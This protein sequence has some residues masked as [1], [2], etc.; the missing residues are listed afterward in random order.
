MSNYLRKFK[1][2]EQKQ[3]SYEQYRKS[4]LAAQKNTAIEK[5]RKEFTDTYQKFVPSIIPKWQTKLALLI[6]PM[7]YN[8]TI[9]FILRI[10]SSKENREILL[11]LETRWKKSFFRMFRFWFANLLYTIFIRSMLK[12]RSVINEFGIKVKIDTLHDNN[13]ELLRFR[14][15][16]FGKCYHEE[17]VII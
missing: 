3:W 12:L 14:I 16:R 10:I 15:L 2:K 5:A 1:R 4:R 8:N 6:P 7:W 9:C 11:Q 13:K 17:E